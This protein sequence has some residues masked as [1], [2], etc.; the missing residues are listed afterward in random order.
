MIRAALSGS[1]TLGTHRASERELETE[2]PFKTSEQTRELMAKGKRNIKAG[3]IIKKQAFAEWDQCWNADL[4]YKGSASVFERA[5]CLRS[6]SLSEC[7][8]E[9]VHLAVSSVC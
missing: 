6:S 8:C 3:N 2:R 9:N 7:V 1:D 4:E 5:L